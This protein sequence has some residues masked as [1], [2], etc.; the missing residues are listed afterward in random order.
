MK[1]LAVQ[2]TLTLNV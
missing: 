1:N 2:I